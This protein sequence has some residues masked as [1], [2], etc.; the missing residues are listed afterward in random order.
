MKP[1]KPLGRY[2]SE[3]VALLLSVDRFVVDRELLIEI[4]GRYCVAS[5]KYDR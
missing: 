4:E 3:V 2:F 5:L 1:G